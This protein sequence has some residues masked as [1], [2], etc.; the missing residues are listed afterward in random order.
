[1]THVEER[2]RL[3]E[4]EAEKLIGDPALIDSHELAL[5][6]MALLDH[7]IAEITVQLEVAGAQA[8]LRPMSAEREGWFR[9]A[10]YARAMFGR[11]QHRIFMRDKELRQAR[12]LHHLQQKFAPEVKEEKAQRH[13]RYVLE[14]E[15]RKQAREV[16]KAKHAAAAEQQRTAQMQLAAARNF[17]R[18]F[19]ALAK[20]HLPA[21][22]FE[23]IRSLAEAK[24][25]EG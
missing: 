3:A 8:Q 4:E 10:A 25:G 20:E 5:E 2:P 18:A 11:A 7:R 6:V 12:G 16:E 13:Q 21:A 17:H 15:G 19:V 9:R 23:A 14:N 22:Q 24:R 1:M